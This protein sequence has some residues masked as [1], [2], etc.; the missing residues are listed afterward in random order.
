MTDSFRRHSR[1][2][3]APPEHGAA[4]TPDDGRDLAAVTRALYVGG[5]G[6][7]AVCDG[8]R[9][10][11]QSSARCRP[12]RCCRSGWCGCSRPAPARGWSA[13]GDAGARPRGRPRCRRRPALPRNRRSSLAH[14]ADVRR[15]PRLPRRRRSRLRRS[16]NRRDRPAPRGARGRPRHGLTT[17]DAAGAAAG[18]WRLTLAAA[19]EPLAVA[20]VAARPPAL[21]GSGLVGE[22]VTLDPGDWTGSPAPDLG[23]QWLRDGAEIAGATGTELPAR[24]G[25]RRDRARRPGHRDQRR[26][27][28]RRRDPA[29]GDPALRAGGGRRARRPSCWSTARARPRWRRRPASP[30]RAWS[31][32]SP[33]AARRSTRPRGASPCRPTR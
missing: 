33:A 15:R 23:V 8:G 12:A 21:S 11:A 22:P 17:Y 6:D 20:P 16:R 29:A 10:A 19:P 5:A 24:G 32:R 25:R 9:H 13:S 4:V 18:R 31:S 26:R 28:R 30:A 7:L 2:L 1:S 14:S 3:T 27:Q